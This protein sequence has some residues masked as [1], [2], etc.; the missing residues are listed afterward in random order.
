MT[1]TVSCCLD[2]QRS[3]HALSRSDAC[4]GAAVRATSRHRRGRIATM[5][6]ARQGPCS[7]ATRLRVGC[8]P[9]VRNESNVCVKL[10]TDQA[11]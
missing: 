3:R 11:F 7:I 1:C 9:S 2:G 4:E 5:I 10:Y 6:T 8:R